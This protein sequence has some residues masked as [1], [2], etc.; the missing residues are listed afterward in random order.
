[1]NVVRILLRDGTPGFEA[2][3]IGWICPVSKLVVNV[4][5][6]ASAPALFSQFRTDISAKGGMHNRKLRELGIKKTKSVP[7]FGNECQISLSGINGELYPFLGTEPGRVEPEHKPFIFMNG[8]LVEING[9]RSPPQ[10]GI[11]AK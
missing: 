8:Y 4:E 5:N 11:D 1:M 6:N 3:P 7:M 9:P 10:Q 2:L